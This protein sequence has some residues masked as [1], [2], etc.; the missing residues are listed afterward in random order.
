VVPTVVE[1]RLERPIVLTG[2][3]ERAAAVVGTYG[4][5]DSAL[6]DVLFGRATPEGN[7]PFELPSSMEEVKVQRSDVP[8]D[9]A[10]PLYPFGFGLRY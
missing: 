8:H 1:I 2:V 4:V 10:H 6:L 7:L 9:T 5:S 3:A